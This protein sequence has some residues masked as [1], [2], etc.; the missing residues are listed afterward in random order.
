LFLVW[1]QMQQQQP[2]VVNITSERVEPERPPPQPTGSAVDN[3]SAAPKPPA[4]AK[5]PPPKPPKRKTPYDDAIQA[6]R[7]EIERCATDHGAPPNNARVVIVV[8]TAG[9]AKNISLQ[10]SNLDG[11]P[12]GAC[13]KNVLSGAKYPSATAEMQVSVALRAT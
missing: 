2:A 3:G 9:K 10:P 4:V 13:I 6:H 7:P 5:Q 8:T 11:S 1:R 12:L